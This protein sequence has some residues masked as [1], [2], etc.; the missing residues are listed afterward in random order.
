[1]HSLGTTTRSIAA[2]VGAV[3]VVLCGALVP[4][5][6]SGSSPALDSQAEFTL[7]RLV[8]GELGVVTV[9]ADG[10]SVAAADAV[11][12][13]R[14]GGI[15][16]ATAPNGEG[17][18]IDATLLTSEMAGRHPAMVAVSADF[19]DLSWSELGNIDEFRILR[20]EVLLAVTSDTSF[21]DADVVPGRTYTYRIESVLP[22]VEAEGK[23]WGVVAEVPTSIQGD[24]EGLKGDFAAFSA[25]AASYAGATIQHQTF[26]PQAKISAPPIGCTYNSPYQYGGDDRGYIASGYPYRTKVQATVGFTGSGTVSTSTGLGETKAYN[27]SG[28]LV[29][30]KTATGATLSA[31]R[32]AASTGTS[33]DV[34]FNVKATNPFC[35]SIPNSIDAVFTITVT[36]TGSWSIITGSHK[37]MPN[38]ELYVRSASGG[39]VNAYKRTYAS[40]LCLVNGACESASMSGFYG[41]Y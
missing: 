32:L 41:S 12:A 25:R 16:L 7:N 39:W 19:V 2:F 24:A 33:V 11:D 40:A 8:G 37:Q 20:D 38:H 6:A 15:G 18:I 21:R 36:K 29:S 30:S 26:I 28:T 4:A 34:R 31:T 13:L 9:D 5:A 14:S 10:R 35:T 23:I 27:S 17:A 3:G 1:M 22:A